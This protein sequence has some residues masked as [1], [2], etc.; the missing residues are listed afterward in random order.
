MENANVVLYRYMTWDAFEKTIA[1][2]SLKATLAS[3]ANDYF[4]FLPAGFL[5]KNDFWEN[6]MT[7]EK[8][9]KNRLNNPT[10]LWLPL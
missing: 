3:D 10:K 7:E 2:W 6:F 8:L 4:E 5:I 1:S 9:R